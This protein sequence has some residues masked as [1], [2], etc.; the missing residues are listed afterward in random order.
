MREQRREKAEKTNSRGDKQQGEEKKGEEKKRP[1]TGKAL[2]CRII[3]LAMALWLGAMG[4]LTWAVAADMY[5]Q[6]EHQVDEY[7]YGASRGMNYE[8]DSDSLPGTVEVKM[9][10]RLGYPYY[11]F[12]IDQLLPIVMPHLPSGGVSSDDWIWGKWDLMYGFEAAAIYYDENDEI[13]VKSG[14]Y[15]TFSYTS[16]KNWENWN[17]ET[18]GQGYIYVDGLDGDTSFFDNVLGDNPGVRVGI[19][20]FVTVLRLEGYFEGNEFHPVTAAQGSYFGFGTVWPTDDLSTL[21]G[22]DRQGKLEWAEKFALEEIPERELETIYAWDFGGACFNYEPVTVNGTTFDSLADLL[23]ADY[24]SDV[25]YSLYSRK[26]LLESVITCWGGQKEDSYGTYRYVLALRCWPLQYAAFRL[27]PAYLVSLLMTAFCVWLVLRKIRK[28]LVE[29]LEY[30]AD[31]VERGAVIVPTVEWDELYRLENYAADSR[32]ELSEAKNEIKQ[33]QTALDYA[34]HAEEN[35]KQ[36]ISNITHELKTP[37]AVIHSYV[38]GL[39][40]GIARGKEEKYLAVILEETERMDNMVLQMLDLS[41]LEAGKVR[42]AA[43]QFSLSKLTGAVVEKFLPM[44][45]TKEIELHYESAEDF[46]ITADEERIRQV[47]TNLV[48]NAVKYTDQGGIIRIRIYLCGRDTRFTIENTAAPLS[49]EAL[50]KVWDSFYRADP[51]R[52]EPGTGLGLTLVKNIV[53]LHRGRCYVRNTKSKT[54]PD[55]TGV[56]FSFEIPIS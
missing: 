37:L 28:C 11:F 12:G 54:D 7:T 56:E 36:L 45:E 8:N 29:P 18:L 49:E 38:E 52:T 35:R 32:Q 6:L 15:L 46:M 51:S 20:L 19:N 3:A 14:D 33:L 13:L 50:S 42:L 2:S 39:Q 23:H 31:A 41:R 24:S 55:Y 53:E 10:E 21:I 43:E 5:E 4:L 48:S 17:T 47:V 27:I 34:H 30:L 25:A 26:N 9:I 40:G 1:R 16:Q 22:L 44:L